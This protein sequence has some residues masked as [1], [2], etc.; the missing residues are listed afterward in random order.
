M[1]SSLRLWINFFVK[2]WM[3]CFKDEI[4]QKQCGGLNCNYMSKFTSHYE[5]VSERYCIY[6]KD[7]SL[8][9]AKLASDEGFSKAYTGCF[10]PRGRT[11]I[12]R[13]KSINLTGNINKRSKYLCNLEKIDCFHLTLSQSLRY[14]DEPIY[15]CGLFCCLKA[16]NIWYT[17]QEIYMKYCMTAGSHKEKTA[18]MMWLKEVSRMKS[19]C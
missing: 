4:D 7:Y 12:A 15:Y 13:R 19:Y 1:P 10:F 3:V 18:L 2:W 8:P 14:I 5:W 9:I 11:V 17:S 6:Y 16:E